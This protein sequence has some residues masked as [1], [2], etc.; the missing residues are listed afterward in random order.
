MHAFWAVKDPMMAQVQFAMLMKNLGLLGGA[1][2]VAHL[3]A[4]PYSV[5]TRR[6]AARSSR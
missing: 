2:L 6:E 5:D 1:L 4:G 3:G